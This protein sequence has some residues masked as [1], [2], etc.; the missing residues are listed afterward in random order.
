[1]Y[2]HEAI[3]KLLRQTGRPMAASEI[4]HELNKNKWYTKVDKSQIKQSQITARVDD[5]HE[6][7]EIDRSISPHQI[8]LFN[9]Q[10]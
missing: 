1:M 7:F 4:A 5:H 10:L 8:K 2:L 3:K 9:R 6:L